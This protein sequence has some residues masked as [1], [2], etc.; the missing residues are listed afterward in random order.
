MEVEAR[1][2][3]AGAAGQTDRGRSLG[4]LEVEGGDERRYLF[5]LAFCCPG[6]LEH[7]TPL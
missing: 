6:K 1:Q 3:A 5:E 2:H 7:P 4:W